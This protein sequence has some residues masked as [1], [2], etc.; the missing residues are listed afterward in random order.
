MPIGDGVV[1]DDLDLTSSLGV[2]AVSEVSR[3]IWVITEILDKI[4]DPSALRNIAGH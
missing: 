2:I 1:S 4:H 3:C